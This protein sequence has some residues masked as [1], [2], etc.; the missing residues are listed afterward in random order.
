MFEKFSYVLT[1]IAETDIDETLSYIANELQNIP[2]ASS[3]ADELEA[4]FDTLCKTPKIG[5]LVENEYFY[6]SDIR[7]ISVKNYI[8]YY[9]VDEDA[10]QVVILRVVYG[11]REQDDILRTL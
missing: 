5:R 9:L 3:L 1:E 8:V 11:K 7:Q 4:A 2:A 10:R 6:R